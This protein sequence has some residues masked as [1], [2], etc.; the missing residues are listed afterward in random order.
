MLSNQKSSRFKSLK[1]SIFMATALAL[2]MSVTAFASGNSRFA[3]IDSA[4][5][6]FGLQSNAQAAPQV[7]VDVPVSLP[8]QV[9]AGGNISYAITVGDLTGLSVISYDFQISYDPAVLVP[10]GG[11]TCAANACFTQTGTLSSS[12]SVTPNVGFPGGHF[13]VSAFQGAPLVGGGTLLILN[14]NIVGSAGDSSVLNFEDYTSPSPSF[15]PGFV[16][17]EGEPV[18]NPLTDG[19]LSIPAATATNTNTPTPSATNT[20]TSTNTSTPTNTPTETSTATNTSTPTPTPLCGQIDIEDETTTTG[21][22]VT[23]SV[24]TSDTTTLTP[25]AFSADF[26]ISYDN[27][28]LTGVPTSPYGV[29]LGPVGAS[30]FS[31]LTVNRQ[32][33]G[34]TTTLLI[35]LFGDTPFVG[36][37]DLVT[38]TFPT[39]TGG[40]GTFTPVNF[41]G[42]TSPPVPSGFQYNEGNPSTCVQNGSVQILG[43]VAGRV[44]Y[45]NTMFGAP[46]TRPVPNVTMNVSGGFPLVASGLTDA[47][48]DYVLSGFGTGVYTVSPFRAA[49]SLPDTHGS[50]IS[51]YDAAITAQKVVELITFTAKQNFVANVTQ[52]GQV[53]SFDASQMALWA[54]T[55]PSSAPVDVTGDWRFAASS[56]SYN[57]PGSYT[58][59]DYLAYLMGDPSGNWC[60][61]TST[62]GPACGP[63]GTII[64]QPRAGGPTRPTAV[65]AAK[66]SAPASSDIVVPVSIQGAADK[67]IISY[68]FDLRYDPKVIQPTAN[69]VTLGGTVSSE[70]TVV[71]NPTTPGVLRVAV[72]GP[73]ALGD[74]GTLLNFHFTAVGNPFDV[75]P[76]TWENFMFNEGG[77]RMN[78]VDGEVRLTPAV[79]NTTAD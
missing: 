46:F 71:A 40:P 45:D 14:F 13:I 56:I 38:I 64:G 5:E 54:V 1:G 12:M 32:I 58:A 74:N 79:A 52:T 27:T 30:N 21:S 44:L 62:V 73:Y 76:I 43:T 57:S 2:L 10:L 25:Q 33:S 34:S 61:P 51:A 37:G 19:S 39:V 77:I 22:S 18:P 48:G 28:I 53:S 20:A 7:F 4:T 47:N 67:G 68:Q 24:T 69:A 49:T 3:F 55:L 17:N 78:I 72:Y 15:H 35:S 11:A 9:Q 75:S 16:F 29:A 59:Q 65:Q 42:F 63:A 8:A 70:M 41:V 31:A 50:S 6:L 66:L 23:L 26:R 36:A 60:D